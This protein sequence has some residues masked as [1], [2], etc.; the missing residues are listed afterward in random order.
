MFTKVL[1]VA[2]DGCKK[3][4][5]ELTRFLNGQNF[6]CEK[7]FSSRPDDI[8]FRAENFQARVIIFL[9]NS[10]DEEEWENLEQLFIC[11]K[12]Q[13]ASCHLILLTESRLYDQ[14]S[15]LVQ[16]G[17]TCLET[18]ILP[19]SLVSIIKSLEMKNFARVS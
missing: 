12:N 15:K 10:V 14:T 18:A 7:I 11:I 16:L 17:V 13:M 3:K 19:S 9:N 4:V 6:L 2:F 8:I 5:Q 1:L